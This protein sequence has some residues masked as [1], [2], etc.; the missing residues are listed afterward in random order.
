MQ[1]PNYRQKTIQW[2]DYI[3]S[4]HSSGRT[5][6]QRCSENAVSAGNYYKWPRRLCQVTAKDGPQFIEV[7][8]HQPAHDSAA[9]IYIRDTEILSGIDVNTPETIYRLPKTC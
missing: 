1:I 9:F 3:D 7:T 2:G 4:C 8:A 5:M 6:R